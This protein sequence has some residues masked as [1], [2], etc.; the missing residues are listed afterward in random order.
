MN[1]T[2]EINK[3]LENEYKALQ[4]AV[5]G[6]LKKGMTEGEKRT[7]KGLGIDKIQLDSAKVA[8]YITQYYMEQLIGKPLSRAEISG[9]NGSPLSL[10]I[11]YVLSNESNAD[12]EPIKINDK[13]NEF[14]ED[15][16]NP[17]MATPTST[18]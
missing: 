17:P 6:I 12:G 18:E 1:F 10:K 7:E 16:P 8:S 4:P 14:G 9:K 3:E 2:E 15:S 5:L 11:N 13:P